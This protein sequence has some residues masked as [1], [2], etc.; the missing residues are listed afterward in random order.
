MCLVKKWM[1]VGLEY[2]STKKSYRSSRV[3]V[4]LFVI[5]FMI[6]YRILWWITL[7]K[8]KGEGENRFWEDS[9]LRSSPPPKNSEAQRGGAGTDARRP[10]GSSRS[11][12]RVM[13]AGKNKDVNFISL[14]INRG[15]A[16]PKC[17]KFEPLPH[18][19]GIYVE[20]QRNT[21]LTVFGLYLNRE[22]RFEAGGGGG[23]CFDV[24]T[25]QWTWI[26]ICV[27]LPA[28]LYQ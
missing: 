26:F 6:L 24:E 23:S 20:Y 1:G 12:K 16:N 11:D 3:V 14:L 22:G 8:K 28:K 17:L 13:R 15:W 21:F 19:V 18:R 5:W 27:Y 7:K 10:C 2:G 25:V 4:C 9:G